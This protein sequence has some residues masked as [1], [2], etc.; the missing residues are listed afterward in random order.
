MQDWDKVHHAGSRPRI[1]QTTYS[2]FSNALFENLYD[3]LVSMFINCGGGGGIHC[4]SKATEPE[5]TRI[6]PY[7]SLKVQLHRSKFQIQAVYLN[8]ITSQH[9]LT[10]CTISRVRETRGLHIRLKLHSSDM[11]FAE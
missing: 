8:K 2:H 3:T 9:I 10:F 6:S 1:Y 4:S 7:I 5:T 11:K